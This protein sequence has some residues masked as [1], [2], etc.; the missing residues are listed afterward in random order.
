MIHNSLLYGPKISTALATDSLHM[1]WHACHMPIIHAKARTHWTLCFLPDPLSLR[2]W[3]AS[4]IQV[5]RKPVRVHA[6]QHDAHRRQDST[7]GHHI[8]TK[9]VEFLGNERMTNR[10]GWENDKLKFQSLFLLTGCGIAKFSPSHMI[11]RISH[12]QHCFVSSFKMILR[13][14][15]LEGPDKK[16]QVNTVYGISV[17]SDI[18][19]AQ[20][21]GI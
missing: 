17:L 9:P 2:A 6:L 15:L 12:Q 19:G 20:S 10:W 16:R 1:L 14:T 7:K 21:A 18:A 13:C 4:L 11:H 3:L 8:S 5:L